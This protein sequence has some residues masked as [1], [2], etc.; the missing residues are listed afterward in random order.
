MTTS[1]PRRRASWYLNHW[2]YLAR[3]LGLRCRRRRGLILIDSR[4]VSRAGC[5]ATLLFRIDLRLVS[6]RAQ[7][8]MV[9]GVGVIHDRSWPPVA[10]PEFTCGT[11]SC[12]N[13]HIKTTILGS[14]PQV[15]HCDLSPSGPL[16]RP[17]A[18]SSGHPQFEQCQT[19]LM[20]FGCWP[21]ANSFSLASL[22]SSLARLAEMTLGSLLSWG[23]GTGIGAGGSFSK[24][25]GSFEAS[26]AVDIV[27]AET[28]ARG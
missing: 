6:L 8:K 14:V 23:G 3:R 15:P 28:W 10:M 12:Q 11:R 21:S 7:A 13:T 18:I 4:R 2:F 26:A 5:G 9:F 22:S 20:K 24:G 16:R 25:G 1:S 27:G 19:P 17:M